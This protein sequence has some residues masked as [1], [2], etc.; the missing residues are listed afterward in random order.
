MAW[1]ATRQAQGGY[2]NPHK[3]RRILHAH[4]GICHVCGHPDATTVDHVIPWAEWHRTD[5]SPHDASNLAPIHELC[6]H[7]GREC[8]PDKTKAEAARGRERARARRAARGRQ[9]EGHPG[10]LA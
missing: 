6:P 9:R 4:A 8:H 3:Q 10:S 7:C 1:S 5:L 2:L